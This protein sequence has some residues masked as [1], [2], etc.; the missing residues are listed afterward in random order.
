MSRDYFANAAVPQRKFQDRGTYAVD[1]S[2]R[3]RRNPGFTTCQKPLERQNACTVAIE[4]VPCKIVVVRA[5]S[6]WFSGFR[7]LAPRHGHASRLASSGES[8]GYHH[9]NRHDHA[10]HCTERLS[11]KGFWPVNFGGARLN[12]A[13]LDPLGSW[14]L[15]GGGRAFGCLPP[16]Q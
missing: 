9:R 12:R 13:A 8:G 4:A 1:A 2:W 11:S 5:C 6:T 3:D 10:Q 15:S 7:A 14:R 16:P